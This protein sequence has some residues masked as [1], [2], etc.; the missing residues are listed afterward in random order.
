MRWVAM[1]LHICVLLIS[2]SSA[3][4]LEKINTSYSDQQG[5]VE[6]NCAVS[7]IY[8]FCCELLEHVLCICKQ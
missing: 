6:V 8:F 7:H 1:T 2:Q 3:L 5:G 4:Q